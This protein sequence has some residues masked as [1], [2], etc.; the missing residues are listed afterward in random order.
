MKE[1]VIAFI[2]KE[3]VLVAAFLLAA[4]SSFW[5]K[6]DAAYI[7]Y[8]DW[9]TLGILFCLMAIMAGLQKTGF[10]QNIGI[11]LLEKTENTRQ[12]TFVLV[13]LCFCFSMVIT[14]DV[15]LLT[16]VPFSILILTECGQEK[17]LLP[18]IVLQTLAANLGSM[19]TPIGNPQNLYLYQISGMNTMEFI[20]IMLPYTLV[21]AVMLGAA[22]LFLT[23]SKEKTTAQMAVKAESARE[24][25]KSIVYLALFLL[26][27]C[28]VA[29]W[30]PFWIAFAVVFAVTFCMDRAVLRKV[31]YGLLLT[32]VGFFIFTGNLG[33]MEAVRNALGSL[34]GGREVLTGVLAS[35]CISNVPAALLLSGFTEN[36][37]DLLIG[38][39]LG[40]LGTLIASMASLIS[41]KIYVNHMP[42]KKGRYFF[43]F[44]VANLVFL[45]ILLMEN[46]WLAYYN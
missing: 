7:G 27:L 34:V 42:E 14:N 24:S 25:H 3:T 11:K 40:G 44:T 45:F 41:Y 36:V 23:R 39:N 17:L 28:V 6:P 33:R 37:E 4:I 26:C 15:S 22:A 21:S 29:R 46:M 9:R 43:W 35:Q 16:F 10:F 2:K 5:V 19:L 38:V 20:K 1:R 31:D 30:I 18:V 12:L 32:F 8:I 13:F